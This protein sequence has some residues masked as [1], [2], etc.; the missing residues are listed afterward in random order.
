M[1]VSSNNDGNRVGAE[2][3]EILMQIITLQD[4]LNG[5]Q[6]EI[7]TKFMGI[8]NPEDGIRSG[9]PELFRQAS[10]ILH[11][12]KCTS[13]LLTEKEEEPKSPIILPH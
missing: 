4:R 7:I 1:S 11:Q 6:R 12:L 10:Q 5:V 13:E 2:T 8:C 3:T 9:L